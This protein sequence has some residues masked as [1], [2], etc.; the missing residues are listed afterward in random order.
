MTGGSGWTVLV[1][2]RDLGGGKTRLSE[3]LSPG[4]RREITRYAMASVVAACKQT[5]AVERIVVVTGS[6]EASKWAAD[7]GVVA[8]PEPAGRLG[9]V[10]VM[11]AA[12]AANSNAQSRIALLMGDLPLASNAAIS[13]CLRHADAR[14]VTMVPSRSGAGTNML[15]FTGGAQMPLALGAPDSL[16]QHRRAARE[17]GL[18][19][20]TVNSS[21]LALDV[22]EADDLRLLARVP[23]ARRSLAF[24][25][26][27]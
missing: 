8:W 9:L 7:A 12:L 15:A 17:A 21:P 3:W 20:Q 6:V 24:L 18:R 19:Y 23:A 13:R 11:E 10:G 27:F 22:D 4:E 16:A 5:Q 14:P 26:R 1:P 25:G 2:L